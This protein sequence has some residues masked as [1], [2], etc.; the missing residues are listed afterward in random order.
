MSSAPRSVYKRDFWSRENLKYAQ[1]HYRMRKVARVVNRLADGNACRLLDVGCGPA[2]LRQLLDPNIAYYGVDIAIQEDSP[3]LVE[4][5]LL[6][7]PID[8]DHA[9][10]DLIVAQGFFEYMADAAV[11]EV[12]RDRRAAGARRQVRRHLRQ[13][14]SSSS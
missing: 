1:P 7:E 10:F 14:R 4:R 3:N 6:R 12:R 5:D 2:T 8:S 11:P 9:P 13:L